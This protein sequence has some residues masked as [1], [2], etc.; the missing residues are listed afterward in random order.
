MAA[1]DPPP[2]HPEAAEPGLAAIA[3]E[4]LKNAGSAALATLGAD[5]APFATLAAI[6]LDTDGTPVMLL[7]RLA[8]HTAN[9]AR[10][11]RASLLI[12][13]AASARNPLQNPRLTLTGIVEPV[14]K[15]AVRGLFLARHPDAASYIDFADFVFFRLRI[16]AAHMVAG[17]GRAGSL[18]PAELLRSN[19]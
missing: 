16:E 9:L 1:P 10:D 4:I 17:F 13:G 5:G 7:S 18:S 12:S 11:P 2:A 6:A 14:A 8:V 3:R 15:E 19:H